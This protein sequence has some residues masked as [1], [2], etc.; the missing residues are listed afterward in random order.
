MITKIKNYLLNKWR[1]DCFDFVVGE[2]FRIRD[3]KWY[4]F[5]EDD[6]G[7]R[8]KLDITFRKEKARV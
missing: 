5:Y 2:M 8:W 6:S 4:M 1:G 3:T 7:V